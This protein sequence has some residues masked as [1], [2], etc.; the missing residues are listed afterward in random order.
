MP[1]S[2]ADL[3]AFHSPITSAF[4]QGDQAV[5]PLCREQI[6]F[7]R[8]NGYVAGIRLL[9]DEQVDQLRAE[10]DLLMHLEDGELGLFYEYNRN[11]SGDPGHTLFHALGA[12]RV[13]PLFHDLLWHPGL[14]MA[15]T[16]LLDGP[17]RLWHDQVFVKPARH[18]GAV[19]WHQD[20]S[21][22][23]RTVP[24]AHLTCWI[25]LDDSTVE[26]GCIHYVPKSHN[27]D[28]L[29]RESFTNEMDKALDLLTP[30]QL[31][32][33]KPVPIELKKGECSFHHP[34]TLHG[35][36]A[37]SSDR[38][39]RA[40]IVNV[41][42]DGV[43]SATDEPLLAGVPVVPKGQPLGGTFFPLLTHVSEP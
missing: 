9:D 25:G 17:V 26:N 15:A 24:V 19:I 29:P 39:R 6:D 12:W 4:T 8:E 38:P 36:F 43:L 11:E 23:T 30:E 32:D 27:W 31:R 1:D 40:A 13:S 37:N 42:R 35:S 5:V 21:Y 33:F 7:F 41:V 16:E 20:Y 14:T 2:R 18:G 34:L 10:L 3:S 28:L 22:W